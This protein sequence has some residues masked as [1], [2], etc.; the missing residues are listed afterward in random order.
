MPV[1]PVSPVTVS[2]QVNL[3]SQPANVQA[4][5]RKMVGEVIQW[6]P[7]V[8]VQMA[9]KF[10]Q[11]SYRKICDCRLWY[12]MMV[13]GQVAVP[14]V[15]TTGT[16]TIT[17]G[18]AIVTGVGTAWDQAF[19][20]RQFRVGFTTG[21]MKIASVESATSMTLDLA[22]GN[23]TQAAVGYQIVQCW[24][25]LGANIKMVLEMV[26][27]RQGY[28]LRVN[29]P[30]A[31]GNVYD[32]WRTQTGWTTMLLSKEPTSDGKPQY[33]LYPSPTSAQ[34]FPFLAY[35]QPPDLDDNLNT[36][37]ITSMRS[38][39]IVLKAVADA[40]VFRGKNSKFYDPTTAQAKLR[41]YVFEIEQMARMDDNLYP[42]DLIWEYWNYPYAQG[43]AN[44]RQEH[45]AD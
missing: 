7:D 24:V 23:P 40:L 20:G 17:S 1:G 2:G 32:T 3:A 21:W 26:N 12:G 22:W 6:N 33:E 28:R 37:P 38:D 13:R 45:D 11:N 9:Q 43:G 34:V 25:T 31:V 30:Q 35:I 44:W 16:V 36:F 8:P 10:I 41:E 15:Y 27:Q 19:V 14:D 42:K 29:Q 5:F 18:S 4:S 39:V